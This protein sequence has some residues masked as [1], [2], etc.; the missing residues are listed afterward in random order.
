MLR[1]PTEVTQIQKLR[2]L[3]RGTKEEP[4]QRPEILPAKFIEDIAL[5]GEDAMF[6]ACPI[7]HLIFEKSQRA[8]QCG[9]LECNT[10]YHEEC[11]KKLKE[12]HCRTCD[13]KL[14]LY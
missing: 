14:H 2:V 12:G 6:N 13:V 8:V 9:N 1:I 5:L 4:A 3:S 7:C 10:L 11:F